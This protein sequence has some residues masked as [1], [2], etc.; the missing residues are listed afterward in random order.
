MTGRP[1]RHIEGKGRTLPDVV[2]RTTARAVCSLLRALEWPDLA[3][4]SQDARQVA[5]AAHTCPHPLFARDVRAV[6]WPEGVDRS[7]SV[8]TLAAS[9][10]WEDRVR[11]ALQWAEAGKPS[12]DWPAPMT[13]PNGGPP[14]GWKPPIRDP[15]EWFDVKF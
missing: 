2:P 5:E 4:W 7:Q 12:A 3:E 6:G 15:A 13:P 9:T 14:P 11:V 10:R 1:W 8:S